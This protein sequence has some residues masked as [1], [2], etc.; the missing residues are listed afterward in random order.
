MK[1]VITS[2]EMKLKVGLITIDAEKNLSA[3]GI[4]L[5]L[6][7]ILEPLATEITWVAT[8]CLGDENKL[9]EKVNLIKLNLRQEEVSFFKR[10]FYRMLNQM[11]ITFKLRKL[12]DADVFIFYCGSAPLFP[13]LFTTLI[14][15]KKTILK[16]D[17]RGSVLWKEKSIE[18][19]HRIV[20]I[21]IHSLS[22]RIAYF[23]ACKIAVEYE[24]MIERY[25]MQKWQHKISLANLYI[26]IAI[27]K[28]TKE[29]AERTYQIGYFG[30]FSKEKGVLEFAQSLPLILKYK[31]S[32]V[33]MVGGGEQ[34]EEI[35]GILTNDN[36]QS[37]VELTGWIEN[38]K[39]PDYL[40]DVKMVIVPSYS[41]GIPNIVLEAMACGTLVLSTP[42][43]GIPDVIKDGE[44]GFIMEDNSPECIA[45]NVI[46]VLNHPKLEGIVNNARNLIAEKY[47][48]DATV[49]RYRKILELKSI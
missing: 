27:F 30:R 18:G 34:K 21:I 29:L 2:A 40:N 9:P 8:N 44:T 22:E 15:R 10:I 41:E 43:G 49:E 7:N 4:Y 20:K 35:D 42:V 39:I 26:D 3:F 17:G 46:R 1:E 19:N 33:I 25:N 24:S 28:K 45:R 38:K 13:F 6:I 16:I 48:Y 11:R 37:K 36:I 5:K 14:L 47:T 23:L 32:K 12:R 31:E